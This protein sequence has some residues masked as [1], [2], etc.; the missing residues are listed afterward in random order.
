MNPS[1]EPVHNDASAYA[2]IVGI[3]QYQ[4]ARIP[5]L[6]YT[7]A[8][9]LG[10]H[11]LLVDP[12]R[13]GFR[14]ENVTLLLDADATYTRIRKAVNQWLFSRVT[15]ES[16]V[17]IFFACHGGQE[18]DKC[19]SLAG[20]QA[21]YFLP[22]DADPEDLASTCLSQNDFL[23]LLGTLRSQRMVVF[24]DACHSTGVAKPGGRDLAIVSAPDYQ[25]LAEGEG[26]VIIAA[27]KPEQRSWED[28][29]LQHG[30]FTYHLL[31]ALRGRADANGDGYVSIQE[32]AAYL[33]REVPRTVRLLGKEPQDPT[34]IC[35]AMTRDII[36]TVDAERVEELL[37]AKK[38]NEQRRVAEMRAQRLKL[39]EL[40]DSDKLTSDAFTE[41]MLII[42]KS[43]D[44]LNPTELILKKWLELLLA[45]NV[46]AEL[47][48]ETRERIRLETSHFT[49]PKP[50]EPP[51]V[52]PMQRFCIFCGTRNPPGNAFC[53]HCGRRLP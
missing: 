20:R 45:G 53:L 4:D 26:R 42:E 16:T 17:M 48:M 30:I 3:S 1:I 8:D 31:E 13:A 50:P 11:D 7:H 38:G 27:A 40:R 41:A 39:L 29:K 34:M 21:Y 22:W 47:Y 33:Q 12:R 52:Q 43:P 5:R 28:P 35:E 23:R 9:A 44:K 18:Q 2:L 51:P 25:R 10:F 15:P 19:D 14:K 37:K 49:R 24:L 6:D 46:E 32:V 36:L